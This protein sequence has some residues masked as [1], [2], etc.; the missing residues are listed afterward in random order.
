MDANMHRPNKV[1]YNFHNPEEVFGFATLVIG[2]PDGD[3][4]TFYLHGRDK[5]KIEKFLAELMSAAIVL[6]AVMVQGAAP[7]EEL[8]EEE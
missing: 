7:P 5:D 4:A 8:E 6:E 2:G 1:S 3:E